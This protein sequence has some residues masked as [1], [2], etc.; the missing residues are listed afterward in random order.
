[1]LCMMVDVK[2]PEKGTKGVG[3]LFPLFFEGG[4]FE[5][6]RFPEEKAKMCNVISIRVGVFFLMTRTWEESIKKRI[7]E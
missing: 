5:D 7:V 3:S 1:M 2:T 4:E 6:E